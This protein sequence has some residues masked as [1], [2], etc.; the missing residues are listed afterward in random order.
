M[1]KQHDFFIFIDISSQVSSFSQA[2]R[3]RCS[4]VKV[5]LR[6]IISSAYKITKLNQPFERPSASCLNT[7][8]QD[9]ARELSLVGRQSKI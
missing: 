5:A 2:Q 3:R 4:S 1:R 8:P 9:K 7:E 6:I